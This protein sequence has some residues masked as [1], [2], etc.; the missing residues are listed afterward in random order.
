MQC[1]LLLLLGLG[2]P[3]LLLSVSVGG[4]L[5]LCVV[6]AVG[7]SPLRAIIALS[8]TDI[9]RLQGRPGQWRQ[10]YSLMHVTFS[11]QTNG[12]GQGKGDPHVLLVAI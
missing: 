4:A 6:V 1:H 8:I 9:K 12:A 2:R 11:V 10:D 5:C 7:W 3:L